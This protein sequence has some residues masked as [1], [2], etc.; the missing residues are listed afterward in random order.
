MFRIEQSAGLVNRADRRQE[1]PKFAV[2]LSFVGKQVEKTPLIR[3]YKS[4]G[5]PKINGKKICRMK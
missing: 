5:D 1:C 2:V 3:Q 4:M